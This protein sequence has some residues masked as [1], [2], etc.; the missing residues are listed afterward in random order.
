MTKSRAMT[1]GLAVV[2]AAI[3][4]PRLMKYASDPKN[5]DGLVAKLVNPA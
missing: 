2:A 1:I 5:K 4:L 3:V